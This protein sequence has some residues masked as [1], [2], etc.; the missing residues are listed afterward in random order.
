MQS[1]TKKISHIPNG[2][3][4]VTPYFQVV[5]GER[6]L[7]FLE[8]AFEAQSADVHREDGLI[9][10]FAVKIYGAMI[11]GS[12]V[13]ADGEYPPR[14]LAIHLYVEDADAVFAKAIAAGGE[15]IHEVID[16]P[17]GERSGGVTDPCGNH[18]YIATQKVDMYPNG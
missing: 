11:E 3:T 7:K 8:D 13:A 9:R 18:W 17:Y 15:S 1:E 2:F 10:H 14:E 5:E 12:Q 4:A 6:F 16:M